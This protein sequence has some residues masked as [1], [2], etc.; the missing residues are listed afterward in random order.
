MEVS[1]AVKNT[2]TVTAV[3]VGLGVGFFA[4]LPA[5]YIYERHLSK[6]ALAE[7]SQCPTSAICAPPPPQKK[8]NEVQ[9]TSLPNASGA[10]LPPPPA[11]VP[12]EFGAYGLCHPETGITAL[13]LL[14]N[15]RDI[16]LLDKKM[17][18]SVCLGMNPPLACK[19]AAELMPPPRN[20]GTVKP[21]H[22]AHHGNRPIRKLHGCHR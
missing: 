8:P 5:N 13:D 16:S 17:D 4:G 20:D 11:A 7:T 19:N 6:E 15:G 2:S 1:K 12:V 21:I 14:Q 3:L 18:K 22:P 9:T 10:S